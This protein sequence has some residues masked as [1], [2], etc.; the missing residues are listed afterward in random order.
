MW[1]RESPLRTEFSEEQIA[2]IRVKRLTDLVTA[3]VP[4]T[5]IL[6]KLMIEAIHSPETSVLTRATRRHIPED[7]ILRSYRREN[8]NLT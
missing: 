1:H 7:S 4:S 2:S 6:S 8:L 5:L 3:N